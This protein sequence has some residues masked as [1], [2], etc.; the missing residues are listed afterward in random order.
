MH[1]CIEIQ[2]GGQQIVHTFPPPQQDL[3]KTVSSIMFLNCPRV[4]RFLYVFRKDRHCNFFFYLYSA[5]LSNLALIISLTNL[6]LW[7]NESSWQNLAEKPA[8][9]ARCRLLHKHVYTTLINMTRAWNKDSPS[10]FTYDK[11]ATTYTGR[12][13]IKFSLASSTVSSVKLTINKH[14][15]INVVCTVLTCLEHNEF[16]TSLKFVS[17]S[18]LDSK[19][20]QGC[21][22]CHKPYHLLHLSMFNGSLLY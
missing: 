14:L 10:F 2:Y 7:S 12:Y 1:S 9:F 17:C 16:Y 22:W 3:F 5:Q 21:H 15:L 11:N 6:D 20:E 8:N 4:R 19:S 18:K 13:L